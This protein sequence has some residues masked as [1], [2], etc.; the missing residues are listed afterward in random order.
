MKGKIIDVSTWER[1]GIYEY[2]GT[3]ANPCYGFNVVMDVTEVL[4]VSHEKKTSFFINLLYLVYL[5]LESVP[6]MRERIVRGEV[7]RY[8][9]INP[10]FTVMTNLGD[11]DNGRA[12]AT[13]DYSLF[14][15][16][17]HQEVETIKKETH[18]R[19]GYNDSQDMDEYYITCVPW[20]DFASMTHPLPDH[21]PS[22]S[23]VPR[24]CWGKYVKKGERYV[25]TL[26][27][28]VSHML[29]D[30]KHLSEAFMAIQ[31][32]CDEARKWIR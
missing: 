15:Q 3:F 13:K 10:A 19:P 21:D 2:F 12:M 11:F 1:R 25:L 9:E 8:D 5:G 26:N 30:G 16:R 32:N 22:N 6:E 29:V 7:I 27:I 23:S 20:L 17:V 28:T 24:V 18:L 4:S 31:K 14:Y